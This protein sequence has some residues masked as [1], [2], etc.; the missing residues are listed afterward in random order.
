MDS[1]AEYFIR[2]LFKA[3]KT[4]PKQLPNFTHNLF[5]DAVKDHLTKIKDKYDSSFNE[6]VEQLLNKSMLP[7]ADECSYISISE[8]PH[9][10]QIDS[11][12]CPLVKKGLGACPGLRV[13]INHIAGMTDRYA[14]LEYSR[15]YFPPEILRV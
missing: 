13:I 2:Q 8:Y 3:F 9:K 6:H 1:R 12:F 5:V 15:L 7:C 4:Y 11:S 10:E 14:H